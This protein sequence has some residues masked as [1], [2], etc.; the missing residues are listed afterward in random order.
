MLAS[1]F[2]AQV[3]QHLVM[4]GLL[5]LATAAK[6]IF[7]DRHTSPL[8]YSAFG[9]AIAALPA[10]APARR[11]DGVYGGGVVYHPNGIVHS[12]HILGIT[13]RKTTPIKCEI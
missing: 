2:Q 8:A 3:A 4:V 5:S 1:S 9:E 10:V 6:I 12:A 13:L 11:M 7:S